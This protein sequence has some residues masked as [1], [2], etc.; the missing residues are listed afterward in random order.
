MW[1]YVFENEMSITHT[2]PIFIYD[3]R[4]Y[5]L[6]H[7][8]VNLNFLKCILRVISR[9]L[10]LYQFLNNKKYIYILSAT[11]FWGDFISEFEHNFKVCS[12]S[13]CWGKFWD[14]ST[15]V[16]ITVLCI[17]PLVTLVTWVWTRK[18]QINLDDG[19]ANLQ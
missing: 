6:K 12:F 16:S 3:I 17:N 2:R 8:D 4:S 5:I 13:K 10:Q 15:E 18:H 19:N 7:Y 14:V 11:E 9:I 1:K